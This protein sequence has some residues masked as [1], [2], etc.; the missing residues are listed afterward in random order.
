MPFLYIFAAA[1][2]RKLYHLRLFNALTFMLVFI[3]F[4]WYT[5]LIIIL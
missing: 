5:F 2:N 3:C 4:Y 1:F